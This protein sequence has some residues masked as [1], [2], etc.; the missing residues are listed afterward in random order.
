MPRTRGQPDII[1]ADIDIVLMTGK[2]GEVSHDD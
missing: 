2:A 1:I